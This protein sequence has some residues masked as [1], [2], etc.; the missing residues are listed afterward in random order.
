MKRITK[1]KESGFYELTEGNEIYGEENGIRLVQVVGQL[2]DIKEELGI[3]IVTLF[4]AMKEGFWSNEE[5]GV[6][7]D[8]YHHP[9]NLYI[10]LDEIYDGYLQ[11]SYS[12]KD[13]G[14][15]WSLTK[16]WLL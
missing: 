8:N 1:K 9:S 6:G 3:S 15:T 12:L 13:Y 11:K 14:V 7:Y 2:E 16:G 10:D 4:T 5:D